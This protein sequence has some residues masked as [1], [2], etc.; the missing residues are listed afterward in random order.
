VV[1]WLAGFA[2][3]EYGRQDPERIQASLVLSSHGDWPRF[4]SAVTLFR[5]DWR[6][7]LVSGGLANEDWPQR[8]D[9]ELGAS[10]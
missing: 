1:G 9:A 5:T 3:D 6:D 7:V 4:L 8:L 2:P 10:A